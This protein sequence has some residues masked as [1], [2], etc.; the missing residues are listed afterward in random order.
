SE[1]RCEQDAQVEIVLKELEAQ[2]K[3]RLHV[4][5]KID[6]MPEEERK[7]VLNVED[8]VFVSAKERLGLD[9][10]L[11][12]IDE[13]LKEDAPK[14]V[15]LSVPQSEGKVLSLLEARSRIFSREYQDGLVRMDV[16]APESVVR[17]VKQFVK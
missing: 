6:L 9:A 13:E 8:I 3:P 7:N 4:L 14:R 11:E 10:L 1:S 12:K 2:D 16:Q 15:H 17:R 5:N